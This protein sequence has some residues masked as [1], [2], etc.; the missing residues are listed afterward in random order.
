MNKIFFTNNR[1]KLFNNLEDN[2]ILIMCAGNAPI[3]SA[4][5]E[6]EF[7]PNR[8][9]YYLTGISEAK[10]IYVLIK[11]NKIKDE[12]LI[13]S[14]YD[15]M[16]K[17]WVGKTLTNQEATEVSGVVNTH[18]LDKEDTVIKNILSTL[19]KDFKVYID[20]D[21]LKYNND[22][23]RIHNEYIKDK[24]T[25]LD[26]FPL[27]VQLR[28]K[29][30]QCEI[31]KIIKANDIT[32]LGIENLMKN[33]KPNLYEY[34]VESCFEQTIKYNGASGFAFK[35]IAASGVNACVL[36]YH[37][38]NTI[39]NDNE[40]ILF[41]LGAEFEYYKS[42]ISRTLPINGKYT[43]RQKQLYNI[44]LGAQEEVFK[45]ARP[46]ITTRDLNNIV[47]KY[48]EVKLKEI[49]LINAPSEVSKYY[50][51]GV[52]HHLGLD[53]H[54]IAIL[55]PL[56]AGNVITVEPGLYIEEEKIG[57]RIEDDILITKDGNINLSKNIIKTVE[58][59][60][61]FMKK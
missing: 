43:E 6:Y 22:L 41:D 53:T 55:Q 23:I 21:A 1:N 51:H 44:V 31:D 2:S 19:D 58:Q 56:E 61:K 7:T 25:V 46:G 12:C 16:H 47:L 54:D 60:E 26:V 9:F 42:D 4:D 5:E 17:K 14:P 18:Y 24:F 33:L 8:N 48:Y 59:I 27:L 38:N 35:T 57:I 15:E 32:Q 45:E 30:E 11:N 49:G 3:K 34:Q 28:M 10:D 52:S 36:H 29:K 39:M 13:I 20:N 50:Y 37:E 40:M